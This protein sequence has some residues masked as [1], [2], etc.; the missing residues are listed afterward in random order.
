MAFRRK[1][2][3]GNLKGGGEGKFSG[4]SQTLTKRRTIKRKTKSLHFSKPKFCA[5]RLVV[6]VYSICTQKVWN[7]VQHCTQM[8]NCTVPTSMYGRGYPSSETLENSFLL[9]PWRQKKVHLKDGEL[10]RGLGVGGGG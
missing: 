5:A 6:G 4:V 8:H 9:E 7:L 10:Q 3:L 1:I 2:C